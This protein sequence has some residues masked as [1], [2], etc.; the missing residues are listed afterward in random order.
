MTRRRLGLFRK[1]KSKKLAS[2]VKI[3]SPSSARKS[4][5]KLLRLFNS[6]KTRAKKVK[7]KKATV[8]ASNRAKVIAKSKRVSPKE[9][10]EMKKVAEIYEKA[11][12]KMKLK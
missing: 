1:A 11:Y 2:I 4:A 12:K 8:C 10:K 9:K 6:A 3:D 5:K 7:I